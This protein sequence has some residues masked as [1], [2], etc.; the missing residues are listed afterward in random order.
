MFGML[1]LLTSAYAASFDC[2][3][4]A[5]E[6]EKL[7]C[8]NEELSRLDESLNKTYLE[9]L[10]RPDIRKQMIE[11]QRQWLKNERNACKDAECL[12]K[13]YQTRIKELG[14]S[15]YGIA[16]E[17]PP[18]TTG[19]PPESAPEVSKRQ[20]TEPAGKVIETKPGQQHGAPTAPDCGS[21][22]LSS[23]CFERLAHKSLPFEIYRDSLWSLCKYYIQPLQKEYGLSTAAIPFF[24]CADEVNVAALCNGNFVATWKYSSDRFPVS[25][26]GRIFDSN[27]RTVH[28]DFPISDSS[29]QLDEW[30]HSLSTLYD[31]GFVVTWKTWKTNARKEMKLRCRMFENTSKP[32][33]R[34]F[35]IY[36][37]GDNNGDF[38]YGMPTGGFFV[39]WNNLD[40]NSGGSVLLR[41]YDGTGKPITGEI[42]VESFW[43]HIDDKTVVRAKSDCL[44]KPHAY[45]TKRAIINI[46]MT[47]PGEFDPKNFFRSARSYTGTGKPLTDVLTGPDMKSLEGYRFLREQLIKGVAKGFELS[48]REFK[49]RFRE[50]HVC[51]A[52]PPFPGIA[53]DLKAFTTDP[54]MKRFFTNYC[55]EYKNLCIVQD[56]E[57]KYINKCLQE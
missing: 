27:F 20:P 18:K 37:K 55:A 34:S 7:I 51:K 40:R 2:G 47:C 32:K 19:S 5:S 28:G 46:F 35:D 13:A 11:S 50:R 52:H 43:R 8:G 23:K 33:G 54:R 48:L 9:A 24:E 56:F 41:I 29:G 21:A 42:M 53:C 14:L 15:S 4:A 57:E 39:V 1:F 49:K 26:T 30:E 3:K 38:V 17:S 16:I 44:L 12:K 31:G 6:V 10:K 22:G 45:I 25:L 36:S